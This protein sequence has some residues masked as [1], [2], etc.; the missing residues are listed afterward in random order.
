MRALYAGEA[1]DFAAH[2]E[3]WPPDVRRILEE[4]TDGAF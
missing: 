4:M 3:A 1:E 2:I